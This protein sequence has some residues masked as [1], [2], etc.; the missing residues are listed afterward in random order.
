MARFNSAIPQKT[1]KTINRA[2][3]AAYKQTDKLE[4]ISLLL[5]SLIKDQYY[6]SASEQVTRTQELVRGLADKEFLAKSAIFARNEFGMRSITHVVAAEVANTVKG[7][8]WT[9]DFFAKVVYRPDDMTETLAYYLRTYG[10]PIPNSLKKGFAKA[11]GKFDSY[12]LAKYRGDGKNV[13][14]V[15]VV[16]LVRPAPTEKNAEALKGLINDNLRSTETWEAK[17][18]AAGQNSNT[19]EEKADAKADAWKTL[20]A[21]KKLGYFAAL[22]NINNIIEQADADTFNALLE[23]LVNEHMIKKS[24]VFPYRFLTAINNLKGDSARVRKATVALTKALDISCANIPVLDGDTLVVVDYS[25][26]MGNGPTSYRGI[27][28]IFGALMAKAQNGD[29]MIFGNSAAYI[30]YNPSIPA[31]AL[32]DE[33]MTHNNSSGWGSSSSV[34]GGKMQV[35]HGTDFPLIF[36]TINK[37][38]NRIVIFSDMQ[39]WISGGAPTKQFTEYKKKF[40]VTP[41]IY[42]FDLSGQGDMMFPENDVYCIAGFSDKI[43]DIM[44]MLEQDCKALVHMIEKISLKD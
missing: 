13:S 25:G 14:L 34:T 1:T 44:K 36:K 35:G 40:N 32:A 3:G 37:A 30:D 5:T 31:L 19:E 27:G 43:F 21:E 2:G 38:Y 29:F 39:G 10:K 42:S 41:K 9:K 11:F 23:V 12:Q 6:R 26:S 17:L 33:F 15:D 16:N 4:F 24:L 22:R 20:L 18:T 7:A 8:D 28:S